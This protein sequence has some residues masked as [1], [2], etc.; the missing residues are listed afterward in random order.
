[1]RER[2]AQGVSAGAIA[3]STA[4]FLLISICSYGVFGNA[5]SADVINNY[6]VETL[7]KLLIP[8]LAQA[9]RQRG[10]CCQHFGGSRLLDENRLTAG[11][12]SRSTQVHET[13]HPHNLVRP[14]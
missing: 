13:V 6:S 7:S 9:G 10:P 1:M 2:Q 4:T 3:A 5:T 14:L 12:A 11:V 8:E